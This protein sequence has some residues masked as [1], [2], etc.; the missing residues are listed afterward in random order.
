MLKNEWPSWK[1]LEDFRNSM[2][3]LYIMM[4]NS[5]TWQFIRPGAWRVA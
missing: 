3:V 2:P 1:R 5:D 4:I